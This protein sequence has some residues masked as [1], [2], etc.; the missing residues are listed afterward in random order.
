[1]ASSRVVSL[2]VVEAFTVVSVHAVRDDK[3]GSP[4]RDLSYIESPADRTPEWG[5]DGSPVIGTWYLVV[6][7]PR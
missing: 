5:I 1:M 7:Y 6:A 4:V 3:I 2:G